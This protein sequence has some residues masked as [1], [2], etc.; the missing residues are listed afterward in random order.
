MKL[1]LHF[2]IS[3]L[4]KLLKIRQEDAER[5]QELDEK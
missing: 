3:E 5:V 2:I 4:E 1:G